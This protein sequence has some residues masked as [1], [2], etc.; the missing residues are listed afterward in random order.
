M[1]KIDYRLNAIVDASLSD[2]APLAELAALA[3]HNGA[4]IIQYRDKT[5]PH[6]R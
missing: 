3:A 4:T 2:I 1:T 5:P 6:A